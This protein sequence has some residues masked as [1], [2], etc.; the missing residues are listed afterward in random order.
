MDQLRTNDKVAAMKTYTLKLTNLIFLLL[1]IIVPLYILVASVVG[2]T[3]KGLIYIAYLV[4][5]NVLRVGLYYLMDGTLKSNGFFCSSGSFILTFTLGYVCS[6]MIIKPQTANALFFSML[7]TAV[8][9]DLAVKSKLNCPIYNR[10]MFLN[11]LFGLSLGIGIGY[12]MYIGG[13]I[14]YLFLHELSSKEFCSMPSQQ[15]FKCVVY[16]NGE[17]LKTI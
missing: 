8:A 14:Q 1:P 11:G 5:A 12:L 4:A 6:L 17:I 16:K 2:Q 10:E 9:I 15:K 7:A 13:A 3:F